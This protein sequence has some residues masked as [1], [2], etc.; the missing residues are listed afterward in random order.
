VSGPLIRVIDLTKGYRTGDTVVP[1][2]RGVSLEIH[3]GE[4]VAVMGPSGSGKSTLMNLLGLLDRP[5]SGRHLLD[6]RDVGG[7]D[8]DA[9]AALRNRAIGFVFQTFNLLAR[10]TAQE[11]VEL[12]LI[13]A[14]LAGKERR[15]R[16]SAALESVGL[17]HRIGHW[18]PQL[19][20]G[21][22]QRVAIAR[23]LVADP[24]LVLADEPTGALDSRTGLEIIA[25]L[26]TLNGAGRTIVMVTHD[27]N[28][29]HHARRI[30]SMQ[31]GRIIGDDRVVTP[32]DAS[33]AV[34]V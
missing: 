14:G 2:L 16:A 27:A 1:A 4:F 9:A 8:P 33:A 22:Q 21:E 12:P 30:V 31:D 26:Q 11:N 19:S 29:A 18:P 32:L 17:G 25:L 34:R 24:L 20:G 7:I 10:S 5:T 15:R 6:G 13:Y 23:A 28:V 3:Q